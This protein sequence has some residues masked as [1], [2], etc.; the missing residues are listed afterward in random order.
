MPRAC[1]PSLRPMTTSDRPFAVLDW[2][3][4]RCGALRFTLPASAHIVQS[5]L[6]RLAGEPGAQC[7]TA[8]TAQSRSNVSRLSETVFSHLL[9]RRS[10]RNPQRIGGG[11]DI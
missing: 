8:E 10:P 6:Q 1:M 9:V 5:R 11:L 3:V 7:R 2:L 4:G